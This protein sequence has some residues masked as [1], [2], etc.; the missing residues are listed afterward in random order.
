MRIKKVTL[1]SGPVDS[2]KTSLLYRRLLDRPDAAG[3]LSIPVFR[4]G[5]KRGY[6][7]YDVQSGEAMLLASELPLHPSFKFRRFFFSE[8]GFDFARERIL[9]SFDTPVLIIDEIG[10]LELEGGGFAPILAECVRGYTGNLVL[11]VRENLVD[12]VVSAF[13]LGDFEISIT[14]PGKEGVIP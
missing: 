13:G 2:G 4:H 12:E 3:I 14:S 5:K 6:Y 9:A 11:V 10:P 7:A 8:Y 1:V